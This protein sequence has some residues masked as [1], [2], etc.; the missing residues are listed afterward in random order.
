MRLPV[1][2]V[3]I[4]LFVKR[5]MVSDCCAASLREIKADHEIDKEL[6]LRLSKLDAIAHDK[7]CL[8]VIATQWMVLKEAL[9]T[10]AR[11]TR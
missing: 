10:D 1:S 5:R 4:S 11:R 7:E 2:F 3:I 6:S 8:A 9:K